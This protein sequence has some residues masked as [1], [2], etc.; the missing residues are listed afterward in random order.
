M[1]KPNLL[2]IAA[3]LMSTTHAFAQNPITFGVRGGLNYSTISGDAFANTWSSATTSQSAKISFNLGID[4]VHQ[5]NDKMAIQAELFYSREGFKGS[6][7][8]EYKTDYINN[9]S[10]LNLPIF[11]KYTFAKH[12]Y[13][14]GGPQ[15]SCLLA[16]NTKYTTYDA[17]GHVYLQGTNEA[18]HSVNKFGFGLTPVIGYDFKKFSFGIRYFAGLTQIMKSDYQ[19][20][21]IK[22][23]VFSV[24]MS[25]R[26]F[27]LK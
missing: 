23:Q 16:A 5:L 9:L 22:S 14:M 2:L 18:S 25:Y 27:G 4:A 19:P 26:V 13:V 3:L 12:F 11:F 7:D 20:P 10:L 17:P 21:K 1:K 24:V 8:Y 15:F 6:V